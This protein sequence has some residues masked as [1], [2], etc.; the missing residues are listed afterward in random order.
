MGIRDRP[1]PISTR[2]RPLSSRRGE[3]HWV[4]LREKD[5][6]RVQ[7]LLCCAAAASLR[8]VLLAVSA[9]AEEEVAQEAVSEQMVEKSEEELIAET[10]PPILP[11]PLKS[12]REVLLM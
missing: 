7:W 5:G 12:S 9:E 11:L 8:Q 4:N 10:D 2:D 6:L 3:K 1:Y